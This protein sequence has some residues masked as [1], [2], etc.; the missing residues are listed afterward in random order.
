MRLYREN[1]QEHGNCFSILS[2]YNG[3]SN[4]KEHGK[5]NGHGRVYRVYIK[6]IFLLGRSEV[7]VCRLRMAATGAVV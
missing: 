1:V 6:V 4:G 3:E 5:R 7:F 2:P